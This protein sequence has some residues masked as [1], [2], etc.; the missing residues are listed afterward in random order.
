MLLNN[1]YHYCILV[2]FRYVSKFLEYQ[3]LNKQE[4]LTINKYQISGN[5]RPAI[6]TSTGNGSAFLFSPVEA[7][8]EDKNGTQL[9][10]KT[11]CSMTDLD[12]RH[13]SSGLFLN[14]T[15]SSEEVMSNDKG[16]CRHQQHRL[17][18]QPG[19]VTSPLTQESSNNSISSSGILT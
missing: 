13:N 10:N 18:H 6:L 15:K 12:M 7:E 14:V 19:H 8:K 1:V 4:Y 5:A 17:I 9:L 16:C 2:I 3:L 11:S